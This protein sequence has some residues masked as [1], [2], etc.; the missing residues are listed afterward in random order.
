MV[1]RY[2]IKP[3]LVV[4]LWWLA[5]SAH[6]GES[7]ALKGPLEQ[8]SLVYGSVAPGSRVWLNDTPI[9]V[10]RDGRFVIGFAR[11]ARLQQ[12]LRVV[13][14]DG[15]EVSRPLTLAKRQYR[16]QR[17]NG[18]PQGTVTPSPSKLG[19][20]R[21]EASSVRKARQTDSDREDFL[22][23][24]IWP[25]SG[26]ISGVYG[27]QRVYNGKPRNPHFGVDVAA[28]AGAAVIAPAGGTVTLAAPDLFY[29]GGT[30]IIDHGYGVS[31]T[32]LH[33]RR[34][35]VTVGQKVRQGDKIGEVGSSGRAT[36]PH[37]DWRMNWYDVRVDPVTVAPA[38]VDGHTPP[39]TQL[40]R[41]E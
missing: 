20:I 1:I 30:V 33:M 34:L 17:V 10:T 7:V 22:G 40:S 4:L 13:L 11:E 26:P 23:P 37:L 36:G 25:A 29:S 9:R 24:F 35:D 32:F 5:A 27:S 6:A 39:V 15:Q 41:T 3:L 18:V 19:R 8:G 12:T 14:P 28:P 2:R 38:L 31:S 21:S 16:I